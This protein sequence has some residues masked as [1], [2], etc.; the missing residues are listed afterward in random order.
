MAIWGSDVAQEDD[1]EQ[2]IRAAL[3]MQA[4]V[5]EISYIVKKSNSA[6][7][8]QQKH[9]VDQTIW[10]PTLRIGINTGPALLGKVG[11]TGEFTAMG[12]T[13][14]I[15]NHLEKSAPVG[16]ILIS[17]NTYVHIRGIFVFQ[18]HR[19]LPIKG[20]AEQIET[21][22]V[23]RARPREFRV[24]TRGVEGLET[25]MIGRSA[26]LKL[27]QTTLYEV[28]RLQK[29]RLVTVVGEAGVGKSRLLYEFDNWLD[30]V[31]DEIVFFKGRANPQVRHS[32]FYLFRAVFATRFQ[33][34]DNDPPQTVRQKFEEGFCNFVQSDDAVTQSHYVG[35]LL[36]FDFSQSETIE[37]AQDARSI[38][39]L[40]YK[41]LEQ[42]FDGVSK[43]N[44]AVLMLEDIHWADDNSLDLILHLAQ[45]CADHRLFIV[46]L[47]RPTLFEN[48]PNWCQ[49]LDIYRQLSLHTLSR[50]DS[51]RLVREILRHVPEVPQMLEETVIT[52]ADGNPFYV[53]EIIKMMIENG[54]ITKGENTWHVIPNRLVETKVPTTLTGVL[55][56]RLDRL[57]PEERR[58]LQRASVVGRTFWIRY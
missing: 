3:A 8:P 28:I 9:P 24:T 18:T 11:T 27:L 30:L 54:V 34:L 20:T 7:N 56:A 31:P 39:E 49:S 5:A 52:S 17:H 1:P 2:A 29:L 13:V 40:G 14:N 58:L 33:I 26:E 37:K 47:T 57:S 19:P 55:Q 36:G 38:Y 46:A 6:P 53:E 12:S 15:A 21:Y 35:Q 16:G 32:P 22:L 44:P 42:F 48:R 51:R 25:R 4:E 43:V 23:E 45:R 10:R 50:S 41:G